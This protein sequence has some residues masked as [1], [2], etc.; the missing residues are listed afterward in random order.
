MAAALARQFEL[1]ALGNVRLGNYFEP[2]R[3]AFELLLQF[4]RIYVAGSHHS[5]ENN[6]EFADLLPF[7]VSDVS[8]NYVLHGRHIY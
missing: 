1:V 3:L 6:D 4:T 8:T 5:S 7:Y 2:A